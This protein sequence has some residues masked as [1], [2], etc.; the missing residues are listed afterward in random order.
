MIM[1]PNALC[2]HEEPFQDVEF[3]QLQLRG[4]ANAIQDRRVHRWDAHVTD[5]SASICLFGDRTRRCV[6][7]L[8]DGRW[9]L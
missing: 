5:G 1:I 3:D 2:A 8:P 9:S 7:D 4:L 6:Q